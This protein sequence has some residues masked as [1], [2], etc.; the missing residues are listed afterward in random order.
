M[1]PKSEDPKLTKATKHASEKV[2]GRPARTVVQLAGGQPQGWPPFGCPP[3]FRLAPNRDSR[4]WLR[5]SYIGTLKEPCNPQSGFAGADSVL[6]EAKSPL[7]G[8]YDW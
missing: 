7:G 5:E 4:T 1:R 3:T 8:N 2:Q 6:L